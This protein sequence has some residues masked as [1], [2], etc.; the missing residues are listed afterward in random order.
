MGYITTLRPR[1]HSSYLPS[2]TSARTS[3]STNC[4]YAGQRE[5]VFVCSGRSALSARVLFGPVPQLCSGMIPMPRMWRPALLVQQV[6]ADD[7]YG[8]RIL[9]EGCAVVVGVVGRNSR[10]THTPVE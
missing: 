6:A 9:G 7:D 2:A 3:L 10:L 4:R 1:L 5:Q 8:R